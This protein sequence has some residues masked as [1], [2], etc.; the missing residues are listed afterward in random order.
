MQYSFRPTSERML[1]N[2]QMI[3]DSMDDL[4]WDYQVSSPAVKPWLRACALYS[5]QETLREDILYILPEE[6]AERFP[7]DQYSYAT[8]ADVMG[9]APHIRRINQPFPALFNQILSVFQ[10]YAE[11]EMQLNNVVTR[12]GTLTDLCRIASDFFQNPVYIH[13]NLFY[14]L[15]VS[16]YVEGMLQVEY[17]EKNGK[18]H[19]PLWL[20]NEFKFD[21]SYNNTLTLHQASIWGNDQ[22]PFNMRSLFVNLWDGLHYCGRVLINELNSSLQPGQF[23]AVEYFANYVL[24]LMRMIDQ[25]EAGHFR[26][27]EDFFVAL[28]HG[29]PVDEGDL[30][31]I[32][33][34][35][36][37]GEEDRY[38]CMKLQPQD[39]GISIRSDSA[40]NSVLTR[41]LDAYISFYH[42]SQLCVVVNLTHSRQGTREIQQC[43][44][45][46]V[47]DGLMYTGISSPVQG[48]YSIGLGFSQ[49]DI[50][51]EYIR[52]EDSS[53]WIC[54]FSAC[55]LAYIHNQATQALPTRLLVHPALPLMLEYDQKNG[56]QYY[57]TL[58]S[59][60]KCE[61]SIPKTS[62][63]LII[64]RTT[65]TYRLGK[66]QELLRLNLDDPTERLYL[67][68]SYYLMDRHSATPA[69]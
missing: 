22:Y 56:T 69:P 15:A 17:N 49:T 5:E 43:L 28:M 1:L 59:Y 26:S 38:L 6:L 63:A 36:E 21:E 4:L 51:M 61:R 52:R 45:P 27:Y 8:A 62:A 23:R 58:R 46:Y 2:L 42:D 60:L 64:H 39:P 7:R 37:W 44:A 18:R 34:I 68:L 66:I 50:V 48:I 16:G 35:L 55:A 47:R 12:G 54:A 20:I 33:S 24:V 9:E 3:V 11:F 53:N 67:S 31:T 32:L 41:L 10:R 14:I 29:T 57:E 25:T 30:Y 19:T 13:D 65:L 40:M